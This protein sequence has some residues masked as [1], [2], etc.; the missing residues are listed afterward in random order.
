MAAADPARP[1][2][3]AGLPQRVRRSLPDHPRDEGP[4]REGAGAHQGQAVMTAAPLLAGVLPGV[5]SLAAA[6]IYDDPPD[7]A[8]LPEEEPRIAKSVA[9]RR[10]EFITGR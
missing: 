8:P 4:Q 7:L 3:C 1:E 6:E 5:D 9:R 2:I 10:N